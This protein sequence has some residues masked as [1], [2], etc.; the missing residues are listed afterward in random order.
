MILIL[1]LT[2]LSVILLVSYMKNKTL[3][4]INVVFSVMWCVCVGISSLGLYGI[5]IPSSTVYVISFLSIIIFNITYFFISKN[6]QKIL[7][8]TGITRKTN[9]IVVNGGV[10][11][12]SLYLLNFLGYIYS[13]PFLSRA[14]NIIRSYGFSGLRDFAFSE[15]TLLATTR[16]LLIFQWIIGPLFV[17]TI[18]ISAVLFSQKRGTKGLA[19]ITILNVCLYT[20]LFGGR[21]MIMK[22]LMYFIFTFLVVNQ[23]SIMNIAKKR[24]ALFILCIILFL[25]LIVLTSERGFANKGFI[26]NAVIYYTGSFTYLSEILRLM[27]WKGNLLWGTSIFGFITNLIL[28]AI[29]VLFGIDYNGSNHIITLM[30]QHNIRIADVVPY[31]SMTTMLFPFIMDF[32]YLGVVIG[33]FIFAFAAAKIEVFFYKKQTVFSLTLYTFMLFAVFDSVMNYS[34]LSPGTGVSLIFLYAFTSTPK[35]KKEYR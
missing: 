8:K 18:L 15:S 35:L 11:F 20:L 1:S 33:T 17:V 27:P 12:K 2:M 23:G 21:Y 25:I 24:K 13:I 30:T 16:Q 31:N 28:A 22:M 19:F 9:L 14:V 34:F 32:G 3:I 7:Y 4:S 10:R 6:I 26:G 29:T 5:Y